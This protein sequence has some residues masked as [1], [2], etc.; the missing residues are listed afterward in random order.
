MGELS[1][2][3]L[4]SNAQGLNDMCLFQDDIPKGSELVSSLQD[5]HCLQ[6]LY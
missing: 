5:G 1:V 3:E 6:S 4:A 2:T